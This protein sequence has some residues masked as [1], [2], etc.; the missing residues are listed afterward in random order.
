[1]IK[2]LTGLSW[3][4]GR[5]FN[6]NFTQT[7]LGAYYKTTKIVDNVKTY[8]KA[9]RLIYSMGFGDESI[10]EVIYS[11]LMKELGINCV[12][13]KLLHAKIDIKGTIYQT[14]ICESQDFAKGYSRRTFEKFIEAEK[15]SI[16]EVVK[17][18]GF[19]KMI[20]QIIIADFITLSFDRHGANVE[21]LA[22]TAGNY[23]LAPLFDN[24]NSFFSPY[25]SCDVNQL[26]TIREYDVIQ[27]KRLGNHFMGAED[28]LDSLKLV[29]NKVIV[30]ELASIDFKSIFEGID[31]ILPKEYLEKIHQMI[32]MRLSYLKEVGLI[33]EQRI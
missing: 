8:Y 12:D 2:D 24:G 4:M 29:K 25:P 7:S 19:Q 17:K 13:Y 30:K 21:V 16:S 6:G 15:M 1:M 11:R 32:T 23:F 31:E 27:N 28:M 5:D 18:Y 26:P 22:D 14:Y 33:E 10:Y 9:S 3:S 20:D